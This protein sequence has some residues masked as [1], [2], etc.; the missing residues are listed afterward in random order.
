MLNIHFKFYYYARAMIYW[1]NNS[2]KA[3]ILFRCSGGI[4]A[5]QANVNKKNKIWMEGVKCQGHETSLEDCKFNNWQNK[6]CSTKNVVSVKC[7]PGDYVQQS[8]I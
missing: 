7:D 4:V 3:N 5:M 6:E 8:K 1:C 2:I